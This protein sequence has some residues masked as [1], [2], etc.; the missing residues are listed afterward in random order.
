M[1]CVTYQVEQW[2]AKFSRRDDKSFEAGLKRKEYICAYWA[3]RVDNQAQGQLG[4]PV[5]SKGFRQKPYLTVDRYSL[6]SFQLDVQQSAG[7]A[8]MTLTMSV[9][10]QAF[11]QKLS[12]L[13]SLVGE[14]RDNSARII[15]AMND[16]DLPRDSR[17]TP[18]R[19][20][21]R[22]HF[23]TSSPK[24]A[25]TRSQNE[26][27]ALI[28]A[29]KRASRVSVRSATSPMTEYS[30]SEFQ[31]ISGSV[32]VENSAQSDQVAQNDAEGVA[33]TDAEEDKE[34]IGKKVA[35]EDEHDDE[36]EASASAA[37]TTGVDRKGKGK[38][39]GMLP[40]CII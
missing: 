28:N 29:E 25:K 13:S 31:G 30:D 17:S 11:D 4:G 32:N 14:W 40:S 39:P 19:M 16:P 5:P 22:G 35:E 1:S 23:N 24:H 7:M 12:E 8:D 10:S 21:P 2:E 37:T 26:L 33:E 38:K 18:G 36:D 3:K 15:D 34:E 9:L 20:P 27:D 6:A